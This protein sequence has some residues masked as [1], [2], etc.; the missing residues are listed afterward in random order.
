[1]YSKR[2]SSALRGSRK[3]TNLLSSPLH[4]IDRYLSLA[5]LLLNYL[6]IILDI[7]VDELNSIYHFIL[8]MLN[9][10]VHISKK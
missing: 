9:N 5:C 4:D 10:L 2:W 7:R 3:S 8:D 1:M 6:Y